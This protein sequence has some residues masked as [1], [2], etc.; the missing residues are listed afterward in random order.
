[1]QEILDIFL[2]KSK[3]HHSNIIY[4]QIYKNDVLKEEFRLFP[5]KTRLNIWSISKP[6]VAMAA[7]IAEREGLITLD[8]YIYPWFEKYFPSDPSENLYKIKIRDLLT[9][10]IR[11]ERSS[12]FLRRSGTIQRKRLGKI[13]FP[14]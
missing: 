8:E 7:G 2:E 12:L 13:F 14:E 3:H 6:F 9:N 10:V 1:M 5:V 11:S 4:A